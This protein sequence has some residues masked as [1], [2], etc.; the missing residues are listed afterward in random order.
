M[1]KW[2]VVKAS[3]VDLAVEKALAELGV[4]KDRVQVEVLQKGGLFRQ[5]E[6]KVTVREDAGTLA[7]DFVNGVLAAMNIDAHAAAEERDGEIVVDI[8]GEGSG[9]AI[10]YRGEVLDA[11]Q[12]LTR[13][14]VGQE[15]N[16]SAKI[17]VDCENYRAKRR[18][19]LVALANRLAEKA[20]RTRRK[21][22]LEPMNPFERRIIHGALVD[23]EIAETHSEGEDAERHVVIVPKGVE[24]R[25]DRP[26]GRRDGR[27]D[28]H[29]D[30]R[31]D[32]RRDDRRGGRRDDARGGRGD[33][34]RDRRRERSPR[35]EEEEVP[36]GR[37]YRGYY[38]DSFVKSDA[39]KSGPPKFKS[40][41]GGKR[42]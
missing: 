11:I 4:A 23:S 24:L 29:R 36:D 30:G 12:F 33:R 41:G 42:R 6:V 38:T 10:G 7:E 34:D 25:E 13:T 5:A 37:E 1:E 19:T 16:G 2:V 26:R 27:R 17:V 15:R 35:V 8:E 9:S 22:V 28:G 18:D 21:V 32:D 14:Y 39:P 40:F 3:N 20:Y 31:R